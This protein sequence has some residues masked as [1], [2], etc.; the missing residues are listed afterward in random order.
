MPKAKEYILDRKVASAIY[1]C[2]I[3]KRRKYNSQYELAADV[4]ELN[5]GTEAEVYKTL[6]L[7]KVRNLIKTETVKRGRGYKYT[8]EPNYE[9]FVKV[10]NEKRL[11]KE[12]GLEIADIEDLANF[13]ESS[14]FFISV[15]K[16][17][18]VAMQTNQIRFIT[19]STKEEVGRITILENVSLLLK[20]GALRAKTKIDYKSYNKNEAGRILYAYFKEIDGLNEQLKTNLC[21][22]IVSKPVESSLSFSL[23]NRSLK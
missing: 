7:L 8:V 1:H 4:S 9:E 13:M 18:S 5:S 19:S 11:S 3:F 23:L 15:S 21:N 17:N 16:V 2:L 6:K 22:L 20:Y 12:H 14:D 10:L